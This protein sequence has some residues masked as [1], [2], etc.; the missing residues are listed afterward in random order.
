MIKK[1]LCI[2]YIII[3]PITV[4][5]ADIDYPLLAYIES[6]GNKLAYNKRSGA[7]GLFQITRSV[8][9]DWNRY[10]K[11]K[12]YKYDLYDPY[13][14]YIIAK[15]YIEERIPYMLQKTG[16]HISFS[17]ILT[18]YYAGHMNTDKKYSDNRIRKY[19]RKYNSKNYYIKS[20][21]LMNKYWFFDN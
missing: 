7:I 10:N 8:R 15:W 19:F 3:V 13:I 9:L 6:S 20:R 2:C 14:N 17:N 11:K 21:E 1:I 4:F 12:Y 5:C 16:K 18:S